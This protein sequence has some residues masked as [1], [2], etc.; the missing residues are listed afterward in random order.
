MLFE[1]NLNCI[2]RINESRET[3]GPVDYSDE[4]GGFFIATILINLGIEYLKHVLL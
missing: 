1:I 3:Q 4:E 2:I